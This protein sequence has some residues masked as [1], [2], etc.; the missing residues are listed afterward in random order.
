[1][2]KRTVATRSN[3]SIR[4]LEGE[5]PAEPRRSIVERRLG[6]S[7]ALQSALLLASI[8]VGCAEQ[9]PPRKERPSVAPTSQPTATLQLNGATIRP[10]YQEM[11][12]IDLPTVSRVAKAQSLDIQQAQ[13]RV[14]ANR[15]R[16]EA[17][18]EALLPVIAPALTY[19][20]F[21]GANQNANGTLV[22]TNFNNLLPAITLQWIVNPGRAYY[23]IVASKRR[24]EASNQE[25]DATELDTLR[26]ASVQ[27]YDLV[28]A[29]ARVA[30]AQKSAAEAEESLRLTTARTQAGTGLPA[31]ELRAKA[32]LAARRQDLLLAVNDFYQASLALTVTLH[33]DPIVTLV[34]SPTQIDQQTLVREDLPI[35]ELLAMAVNNRPDLEAARSLLAAAKADEKGV[36]WG[37]LGP[38]LQAAYSYGGIKTDGT[39]QN[40]ALHEQQKGSASA[41]FNLGAS[42][43][44]NVK[45]AGATLRTTALEVERQLDQIRA[46]VVSAQQT[47]QTNAALIPI[48]HEQV[49]AAE[50]ALRLAQANLRQGTLLLVDVLQAEDSLDSARL[51]YADA[52]LHYNQSQ[53]NL[54]AALGL[55]HEQSLATASSAA[56]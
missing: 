26:K 31:D 15:G 29:Q 6:G 11:L 18:V 2:S 16:Y 40:T 7:L 23:D 19:Q 34:P 52:V 55:L 30:V 43:F 42:T 45:S 36:L 48:A 46:Q 10:M 5:A 14:Q 37:A 20:H 22:S 9:A 24:L 50:E 28:L 44:G 3:A 49:T 56:P 33:L 12:A 41:G 53:V 51:R 25:A 47:S 4:R 54:L 17:S 8:A 35:Q 32:S 27:Y 39:N 13:A 1:M 38:Q 21:E